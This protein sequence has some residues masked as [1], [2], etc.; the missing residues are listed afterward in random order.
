MRIFLFIC[1][2]FSMHS[3]GQSGFDVV[4]L[5]VN[6]GISD[7]NLTAFFISPKGDDRGVMCDAGTLVNGVSV[8]LQQDSFNSIIAPSSGQQASIGTIIKSHIKGYLISHSHLDHVAG[9]VIA[10]VDDS[11]KPIYAFPSVIADLQDNYFNWRAWPNFADSGVEPT[12]KKY[13]Y[14]ALEEGKSLPLTNTSM[15]VTPFPLS[16]GGRLSTAFLIEHDNSAL[17]CMG[18]TGADSIEKSD[19]LA[20]LWQALAQRLEGKKLTGIIIESSY[21]NA[22]PDNLLFGHLTPRLV[23]Q[24]LQDFARIN[25]KGQSLQ[26]VKVLI[27]HI[28]YSLD[29]GFSNKKVIKEQLNSANTLGVEFVIP[30]QGDYISFD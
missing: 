18:D 12:L 14:R 16:H 30:T 15:Q 11:K 9:L 1:S 13:T 21:T 26:G 10:S 2:L 22:R 25:N 27:S 7:G 4:A 17:L 3:Y 8:A 29:T 6:G 5:G 24:S 20:T 23:I 28:K 19:H